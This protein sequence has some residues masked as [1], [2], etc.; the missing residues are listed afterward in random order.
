[1]KKKLNDLNWVIIFLGAIVLFVDISWYFFEGG[2]K[3]QDN[4]ALF[5]MFSLIGLGF[6]IMGLRGKFSYFDE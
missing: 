1:M 5:G 2:S 3:L 6:I 4:F